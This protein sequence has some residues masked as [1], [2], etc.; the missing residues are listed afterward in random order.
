MGMSKGRGFSVNDFGD[1]AKR[2]R[3]ANGWGFTKDD[4]A[5][6]HVR[7]VTD[8]RLVWSEDTPIKMRKTFAEASH[9]LHY[10]AERAIMNQ[11][12]HD[13]LT[14]TEQLDL[15]YG[16]GKGKKP[17]L[18]RQSDWHEPGTEPEWRKP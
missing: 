12:E 16:Q 8:V 3:E 14:P 13:K 17:I 6:Y 11:L 4:L 10:I 5:K 7:M 9:V 18:L 2:Q 15:F 1:L